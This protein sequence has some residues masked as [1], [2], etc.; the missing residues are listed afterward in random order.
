MSEN[1]VIAQLSHDQRMELHNE[2]CSAAL[3]HMNQAEQSSATNDWR[4]HAVRAA[5]FFERA[6]MLRPENWN[7]MWTLGKVRQMLQEH[8]QAYQAF[9][10]AYELEPN[11]P[12][13]C[14][15]LCQECIALGKGAEAVATAQ[16]AGGLDP[17]DVGLVANLA[18]AYLIDQQITAAVETVRDASRR[19]PDDPITDRLRAWIEAVERNEV[20]AP[21]RWPPQEDP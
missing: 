15:E 1:P 11:H 6:V 3:D 12:D 21:T 16:R 20:E 14:R 19:D 18:F 4:Q 8:E 17:D 13:V 9:K 5:E 10:A 2:L 7:A